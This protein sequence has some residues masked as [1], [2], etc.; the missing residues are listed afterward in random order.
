M[1]RSQL[2]LASICAVGLVSVGQLGCGDSSTA[3]GGGGSGGG[4]GTGIK[5]PPR[6]EGAGPGD[7]PGKVYGTSHIYIGTKTRS[8]QESADAWKDYGYDLDGQITT[9]DFS[10]HCKP[11]G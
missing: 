9:S 8:G 11:A 4:G 7:G 1:L 5:P 3:E 10:N 2:L 6:P